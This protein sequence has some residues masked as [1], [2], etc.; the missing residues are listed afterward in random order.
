MTLE[1]RYEAGL[2]GE[3]RYSEC[4][5]CRGEGIL[6]GFLG[7]RGWVRCRDCAAVYWV[8]DAGEDAEDFGGDSEARVF[9]DGPFDVGGEG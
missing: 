6:L 4:P 3:E 5:E 2:P 7:Y 1:D 9:E 8:E